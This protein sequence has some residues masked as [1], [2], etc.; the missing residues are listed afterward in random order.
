VT[1]PGSAGFELPLRSAHDVGLLGLHQ[2]TRHRLVHHRLRPG[3]RASREASG[4]RRADAGDATGRRARCP[5]GG[6]N[7]SAL[8]FRRSY[9]ASFRIATPFPALRTSLTAVR[10]TRM[11]LPA[12]DS[13][14]QFDGDPEFPARSARRLRGG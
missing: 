8:P 12:I 9:A 4:P 6:R 1:A 11:A 3:E 10:S 13:G 7:V 14:S 2:S 5:G